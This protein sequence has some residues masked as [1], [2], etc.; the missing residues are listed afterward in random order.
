M[1]LSR[2]T[3]FLMD[4]GAVVVAEV[5][6]RQQRPSPIAQG[7]GGENPLQRDRNYFR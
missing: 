1:E 4:R 5:T 2:V 3:K 6:S 7:G